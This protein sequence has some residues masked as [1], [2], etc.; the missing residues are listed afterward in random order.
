M[1]LKLLLYTFDWF[2]TLGGV[3]SVT[4]ALAAGLSAQSRPGESVSV[5]LVTQ[6]AAHGM[7][8]SKFPFRVVR[9]PSLAEL[10]REIRSSDI[11]HTAGPALR[12]LLIS[13]LLRKPIVVEHHG[14]QSICP[15]GLLLLGTD[16][17]ACPGHFTAK[18]Y[19]KCIRCGAQEIG[20]LRSFRRLALTFVRRSLTKRARAHVAPSQHI[21]HRL[22]LPHTQVIYHGVAPI[23]STE[24]SGGQRNGV[25]RFA[26]VGRLVTEKGVD[27]LLQAAHR[28]AS[29]ERC[30]FH[31]RIV[32]DGP[33]R[34]RLEKIVT[35]LD[36]TT[37]VEFMGGIAPDAVNRVLAESEVIVMP[38]VWEEVAPMVAV[39]Q[40]MQGRLVIAS[41]LAGLSELVGENGLKFTA[42]D[43]HALSACMRRAMMDKEM[44]KER[45]TRAREYAHTNYTE[46]RMIREHL[47]LYR[48][49]LR[50]ED[51]V[52]PQSES[53]AKRATSPT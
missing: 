25:T 30:D 4:A 5:T 15:N 41:D 31:I 19:E 29:G 38:S 21:N 28:L 22:S 45:S 42:G 32:G 3:Q 48:R 9:E 53:E 6:R 46:Q 1:N 52:T 11:V 14:Y 8:D 37:R 23:P 49:V 50:N 10:I 24:G 2:P 16:R 44:A 39:E 47:E 7:D 17:S 20:W 51:F 12:P 34:N 36:L 43:A 40:M 18:K 27:I 33:E 35:E 26:F 13:R